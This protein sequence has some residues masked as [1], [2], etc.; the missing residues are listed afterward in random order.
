MTAVLSA[1]DALRKDRHLSL[2]DSQFDYSS[3]TTDWRAKYNE[4]RSSSPPFH[5]LG[6]HSQVAQVVDMLAETRNELEEFQSASRELE[7]EMEADL[8]RSEKLEQE[9]RG[10]VANSEKERDEWKG[11]YMTLQ[12]THNTTTTS[13]QRELDRLRQEYQTIKIKLRDLEL[14]N[15]DLE[16]NERVASSS[17]ADMEAKYAKALEEKILLEHEL[18]EKASLEEEMQRIKDELRDSQDEV[19]ILREQLAS[20]NATVSKSLLAEKPQTKSSSSSQQFPHISIPSDDDLLNTKPPGDLQLSD[21]SPVPEFMPSVTTPKANATTKASGQSLLLQRA[22]FN[23]GKSTNLPSPISTMARS[24]TLPTLSS[25]RTPTTRTPAASTRTVSTSSTSTSTTAKNKGVQMVSEMRARVRVLEQKIHTRVPRL[26]MASI[27]GRANATVSP[28]SA[29]GSSSSSSSASLATTAKTSLDS[30]RRSVDS[31][32]SNESESKKDKAKDNGDSSG[33][34]LI[35]EDSPSP[36][37]N[38]ERERQKDKRRLSSPSA[39][40]AYRSGSSNPNITAPS[41]TFGKSTSFAP[42]TMNTGIRRPASRLS[43]AS[44]S[45][46]TTGSSLPTPTSRPATPT[47]L[48]LPTSSLYANA[49]GIG[50]K[51]STGPGGANPYSG[52]QKRTSLGTGVNLP[53]SESFR[54][55]TTTISPLHRPGSSTPSSTASSKYDE[56]RSLPQLPSQMSHHTN[57]TIRPTKLPSSGN[58]AL[59]K[60][61]IGRPGGAG[62]RRSG[63]GGTDSGFSSGDALDIKDL[64]SKSSYGS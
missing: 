1:T 5:L 2:D 45:T 58:A 21:L 25:P 39:P 41:P 64:R 12:T 57:V 4:V 23:P 26:R 53:T 42:S 46:A 11:K 15:D 33:W 59:S 37:K 52:G 35:M 50:L 30:I 27:T 55:K 32:R 22:G 16:R 10:K 17:L 7:A 13:L 36:Q 28:V 56:M 44:L 43:G 8:A 31:R 9:L 14:G 49:S 29:L 54:D 38:K 61:R 18:L 20:A 19:T 34:V 48:P 24:T 51:R 60:S 3:A 40:S 6:A 47:F 62:P 63:G